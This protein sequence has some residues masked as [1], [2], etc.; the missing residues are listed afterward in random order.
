ML[1]NFSLEDPQKRS[2][3]L[4]SIPGSEKIIID[5]GWITLESMANIM[6]AS[7]TCLCND[8]QDFFQNAQNLGIRV[9]VSEKPEKIEKR[10]RSKKF[11]WKFLF[12]LLF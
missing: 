3:P 10:R 7:G 1:C 6:V 2:I 5:R 11:D 8:G 12:S 4:T 9:E